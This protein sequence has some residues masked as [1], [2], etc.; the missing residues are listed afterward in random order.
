MEIQI[1]D[2]YSSMAMLE[3]KRI[4]DFLHQHLDEFGD[5]KDAIKK[6]IDYSIGESSPIGGFVIVGTIDNKMAGAVVVNRTGM[7]DYIPENILVYIAVDSALRGKGI[8]KQLMKKAID[9][10]KGNIALHVEANN[11]A[12][13]LYEKFG[14]T[15]KY[16]EYRL[17]RK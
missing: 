16:L 12:L 15:S 3:K 7:E 14:F 5:T 4:I 17:I 10:S 11:P 9:L 13:F 2:S 8:G 1:Y 6:A